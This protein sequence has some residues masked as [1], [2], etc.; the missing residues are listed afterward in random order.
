MNPAEAAEEAPSDPD[1]DAFF[2]TG[3][4]DQG[5]V[6]AANHMTQKWARYGTFHACSEREE[7]RSSVAHQSTSVLIFL[8]V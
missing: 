1:T 7:G 5:G 3:K 6:K 4:E 2:K 8:I